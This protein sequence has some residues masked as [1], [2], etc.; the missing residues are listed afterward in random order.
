MQ[1]ISQVSE[2]R[3]Q[4]NTWRT[5]SQSIALV[6]TMGNLHAGHLALVARGIAEA[7]RVIVSIFVNPIQ[8][9]AGEDYKDYPRTVGP[10]LD[11]LAGMDTDLVFLPEMDEIFPEG[12]REHTRVTVPALDQLHCG[13]FRPGHFTGVATIVVKLLNLVQPDV[14]IFGEKDYQQLLVIRRLVSDLAIPVRIIGFPIVREQDGLAMSS[15]NHYLSEDERKQAPLLYATLKAMADA[16]MDGGSDYKM[17]EDQ[18][19]RRLQQSGFRPEYVRV[20][21]AG[22][23][24][25]PRNSDVVILAAAWLGKTRMIDNIAVQHYD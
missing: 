5:Q 1:T 12:L 17:L 13:E 24:G 9:V 16:I 23:L 20:C 22:N 11:K 2:L 8:F 3:E 14:A 10:D 25:E 4:V 15:R 7:D 21:D 19:F 6:P 18:A